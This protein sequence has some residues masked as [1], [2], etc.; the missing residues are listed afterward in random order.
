ME[1][2]PRFFGG[3]G[4][5]DFMFDVF[6]IIFIIMFVVILGVIVVSVAKGIGQWKK[7][8]DSPI[9]DS[10][11]VAVAKRTDVS[12]HHHAGEHHHSSSSTYYHVTFEFE[13]GSRLELAVSGQQYGQIAE[14]DAGMLRFQGT[15]FLGFERL[16]QR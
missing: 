3:Y 11:V 16:A 4:G 10:A 12:S 6:P 8:N 15:R 9:L 1:I 14:G 2:A 7:N 5:F 13:S